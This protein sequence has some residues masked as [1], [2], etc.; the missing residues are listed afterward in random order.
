MAVGHTY[1]YYQFAAGLEL[2]DER[3]GN[4]GGSR[5][6]DDSVVGRICGPAVI[7][8]SNTALDVAVTESFQTSCGSLAQ[9]PDN[10]QCLHLFTQLR[11]GRRLITLA[12]ANFQYAMVLFELQQ[13]SYQCDYVG[14]GNG[15]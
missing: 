13:I 12:G 10:F 3:L 15:R 4:T 11:D 14:L 6:S 1:G 8:I 5:S 9:L 2:F 7:S